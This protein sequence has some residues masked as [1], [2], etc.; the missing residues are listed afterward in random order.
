MISDTL[1]LSPR[2]ER[3][4]DA[5]ERVQGSVATRKYLAAA[6]Y[7]PPKHSPMTFEKVLLKVTIWEL[8]HRL[9]THFPE[10]WEIE[11]VWGKGYRLTPVSRKKNT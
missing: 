8:R 4:L 10:K 9:S 5:L 3:C 11:T 1:A 6:M 2:L 7:P